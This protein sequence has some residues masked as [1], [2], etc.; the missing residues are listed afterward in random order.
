MANY[1]SNKFEVSDVSALTKHL[2]E[3]YTWEEDNRKY[4]DLCNRGN[5]GMYGSFMLVMN[6]YNDMLDG[7]KQ[8]LTANHFKLGSKTWE[9]VAKEVMEKYGVDWHP[10]AEKIKRCRY[11]EE[12]RERREKCDG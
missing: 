8:E 12:S 2:L 7:W 10:S 9:W 11:T 4:I 6:T 3:I 5:P 1:I